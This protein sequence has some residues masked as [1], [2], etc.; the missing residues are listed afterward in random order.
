MKPAI[1]PFNSSAL[2]SALATLW[3]G[4]PQPPLTAA[5]T[6]PSPEQIAFFEQHIRPALVEH[7]YQCHSQGSQKE[8]KLKGG[9]FLDT[10]AGVLKGGDTGPALVA[11]DVSASLLL[12][13]VRWEDSDTQM[14]PKKKLP[15]ELIAHLEK[16]VA[17]GAP[18]PRDGAAGTA[19]REINIAQGREHWAFKPLSKSAPPEVRNSSWPRTPVDR[20]LLAAQEAAGVTPSPSASKETLLRRVSFDLTGLPPK[21]EQSKP[22]STTPTRMPTPSW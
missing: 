4:C 17:M 10:R 22:S 6:T 11:G 3:L 9:L 16:W 18:D 8:G 15:P 1:R 14:P 2:T 20:F 7:C 19:K 12:K 5:E 21:P 13:A